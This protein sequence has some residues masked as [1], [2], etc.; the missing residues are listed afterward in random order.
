MS[1]NRDAGT[2]TMS[3]AAAMVR[4]RTTACEYDELAGCSAGE[5]AREVPR[6]DSGMVAS[7]SLCP[8]NL[9]HGP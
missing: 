6:G 1:D 8:A 9:A 4:V 5:S 3:A 2:S 7:G